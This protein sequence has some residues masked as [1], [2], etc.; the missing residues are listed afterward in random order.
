MTFYEGRE[1]SAY[2]AS[3]RRLLE[4]LGPKESILDVGSWDSPVATWG[5]FRIR[6]T[7]D[8]RQRPSIPE[9]TKIVGPWPEA[10]GL[11]QTPVSVVTCL[12]VLEHVDDVG[13]FA[14]ALFAMARE[15]VII[16]VPY[17]WPS[18]TCKHHVHDPIDEAKLKWMTGKTPSERILTNG[19]LAR[20]VAIY[21][22]IT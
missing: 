15:C 19:K 5:D 14:N 10:T 8:S 9:V 22:V 16:S 20:M 3:V 1:N 18:G 17:K 12:Q 2:Y 4:S 13:A 11:F 7:V 6:Y 21:D